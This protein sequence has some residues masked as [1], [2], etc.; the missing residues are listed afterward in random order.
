MIRD[1]TTPM[2]SQGATLARVRAAPSTVD[3]SSLPAAVSALTQI[4]TM[5]NSSGGLTATVSRSRC[6][7]YQAAAALP[8]RKLASASGL[9]CSQSA[10]STPMKNTSSMPAIAPRPVSR[11][12]RR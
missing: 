8:I 9:Q 11:G 12:P 10:A 5:K 6:L 1:S 2:N 4:T 7:V 3:S